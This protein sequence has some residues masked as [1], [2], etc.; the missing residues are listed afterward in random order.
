MYNIVALMGE[1][2]SGKD[3]VLKETLIQFPDLHKIITS[4]S[5][6]KR[7]KE[8]DG[9][10]YFYY[11][12]EEFVQKIQ[13]YEM[14]DWQIF[15]NWQ[16]GTELK[17]LDENKINIGV[18][19]PRAIRTLLK[20]KDC[21]VLAVWVR[22]TDKERLLRQ[23]NREE[24]PNV[25]EIVRRATTDYEDFDNIEFDYYEVLNEVNIALL[26]IPTLI[27]GQI[28]TRFGLGQESSID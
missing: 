5:R 16:Y 20:R 22:T 1:S 4:T 9:I 18:F 11:T 2:G 24:N 19:S 17:A 26:A 12:D 10:N 8:E 25:R 13:N 7:E 14:L 23:L 27:M 21:N 15:N 3:T 28:E 6:P